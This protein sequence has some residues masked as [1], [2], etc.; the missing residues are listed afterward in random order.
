MCGKG[1]RGRNR[2]K[3]YFSFLSLDQFRHWSKHHVSHVIRVYWWIMRYGRWGMLLK[4][5]HMCRLTL[6]LPE[7]LWTISL[8]LY[9]GFCSCICTLIIWDW[10]VSSGSWR[11]EA[12]K[13]P[14]WR[15]YQETSTK[16]QNQPNSSST[17]EKNG[18]KVT[19]HIRN[20]ST[21][22]KS[23]SPSQVHYG[24]GS[25]PT[26]STTTTTTTTKTS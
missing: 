9:Q 16:I 5:M 7:E 6:C 3:C 2:Q 15:I 24:S 20:H 21:Q 4:K 25:L 14:D 19:P 17:E 10:Y 8:C 1:W 11:F 23:F 18:P 12:G 13:A 26:S 22:H